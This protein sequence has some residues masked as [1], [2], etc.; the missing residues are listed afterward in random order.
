MTALEYISQFPI[1]KSNYFLWKGE[2]E[3]NASFRF[4]P[5][6]GQALRNLRWKDVPCQNECVASNDMDRDPKITY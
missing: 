4:R 3:Q 5:E 1:M 6:I 2:R